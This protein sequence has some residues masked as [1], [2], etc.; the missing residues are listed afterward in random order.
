M[1][2]AIQ[3][4]YRKDELCLRQTIYEELGNGTI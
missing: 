1:I 4:N 2:M 3:A